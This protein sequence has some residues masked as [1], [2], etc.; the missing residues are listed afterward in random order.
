MCTFYFLRL[1]PTIRVYS[2][3]ENTNKFNEELYLKS[4][5]LYNYWYS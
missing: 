5:K 1:T 4:N 3:L 2:R